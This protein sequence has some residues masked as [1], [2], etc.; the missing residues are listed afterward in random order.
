MMG[1]NPEKAAKFMQAS[2]A[3]VAATNC[4]AGVGIEWMA[5]IL[6]RYRT[7]CDLPL[8]AMPNAGKPLLEGGRW[9]YKQP[10]EEMA[11]GVKGLLDAGARIV[12]AC[13]GSTAAHIA[14]FRAVLDLEILSQAKPN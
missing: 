12:G 14:L 3:H 10:P 8:M 7:A 13:C 11:A 5:R 9:V 4:G 6:T 2:G 1:V